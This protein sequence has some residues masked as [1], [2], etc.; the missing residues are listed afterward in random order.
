MYDSNMH[1]KG[2]MF[3][4]SII[5]TQILFSHHAFTIKTVV[6]IKKQ[7]ECEGHANVYPLEFPCYTMYNTCKLNL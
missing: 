1:L 3:I 6:Y 5:N 4:S 7:T 2:F